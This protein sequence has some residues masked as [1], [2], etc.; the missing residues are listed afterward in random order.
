MTV[1][2]GESAA[3]RVFSASLNSSLVCQIIIIVNFRFLNMTENIT[4]QIVVQGAVDH[5]KNSRSH[6]SPM[7][8]MITKNY[9][10]QAVQTKP[11]IF[12]LFSTSLFNVISLF[13]KYTWNENKLDNMC[14][15]FLV[16]LSTLTAFITF[17]HSPFKAQYRHNFVSAS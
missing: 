16:I 8:K 3:A 17:S 12:I 13:K 7:V 15:G 5:F 6:Q 11:M 9:R 14:R 4:F 1:N 10:S 2:R